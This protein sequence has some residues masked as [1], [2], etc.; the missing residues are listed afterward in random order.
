[1]PSLDSGYESSVSWHL[2]LLEMHT[3]HWV[4][5]LTR[6]LWYYQ[7]MKSRVSSFK[8]QFLSACLFLRRES[9]WN[10]LAVSW[11]C[12]LLA[13]NQTAELVPRFHQ[14]LWKLLNEGLKI[15]SSFQILEFITDEDI[16]NSDDL[17]MPD[18]LELTWLSSHLTCNK[19][20]KL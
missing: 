15:S 4:S 19:V 9:K 3:V 10:D 2:F 8:L 20:E 16:F 17:S 18:G 6:F 12:L 5:R 13:D 11:D 1:M 14:V 7:I